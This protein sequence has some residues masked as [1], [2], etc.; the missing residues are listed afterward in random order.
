MTADL[1][2]R[3]READEETLL[4]LLEAHVPEITPEEASQALANPFLGRAGIETMAE[5][6]R[7]LAHR[8]IQRLLARHR[9]TPEPLALR[10]VPGLFW[11]DLL[12]IG[13]DTR[14][15]PTVRRAAD[16]TLLA[17]LSA[18]GTGEK[19]SIARRASRRVLERLRHDPSARVVSAL[20]DNPRLT[21]GQLLPLASSEQAP[22]P[23]LETV[24][25]HRRWGVRYE[26]RHALATN[27]AVPVPLVLPILPH[28]RKRDLRALSRMIRLS[29]VVRRR[30]Q[31]LLGEAE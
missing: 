14:V 23:V 6:K 28:L 13:L 4:A 3:L 17:R 26:V 21:E 2:T 5:E 24:A 9:A 16:R 30:A 19:V 11:K 31:V 29:P 22:A 27:P 12:E 18:L 15:R 25:R 7:L 1:A 8:E 20:L 10:M